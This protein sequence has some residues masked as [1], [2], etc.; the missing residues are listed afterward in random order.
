[1]IFYAKNPNADI[2]TLKRIL[3]AIKDKKSFIE[4]AKPI[5]ELEISQKKKTASIINKLVKVA[6]YIKAKYMSKIASR[7]TMNSW[8]K[9]AKEGDG[10]NDITV[11]GN[12]KGNTNEPARGVIYVEPNFDAEF[13]EAQRYPEFQSKQEWLDA[14]KRGMPVSW[15]ELNGFVKNHDDNIDNL[16]PEKV[17][18]VETSILRDKVEYPIVG[19]WP[20][21]QLELIAGNTRVAMLKHLG[22]DPMVWLMDVQPRKKEASYFFKKLAENLSELDS[23]VDYEQKRSRYFFRR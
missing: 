10:E 6:S 8:R 12:P 9:Y 14:A 11:P 23:A 20:N 21:G 4:A 15:S 3:S 5:A 18:R 2:I 13:E 16:D 7:H 22:H 1:M 19:R 17:D